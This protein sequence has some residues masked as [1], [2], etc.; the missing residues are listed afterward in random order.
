M[1]RLETIKI[2]PFVDSF[3]NYISLVKQSLKVLKDG[4]GGAEII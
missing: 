3:L 2:V 1:E 4:V